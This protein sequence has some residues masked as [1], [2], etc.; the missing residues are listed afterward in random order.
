LLHELAQKHARDRRGVAARRRR[1]RVAR[2]GFDRRASARAGRPPSVID[3]PGADGLG[4]PPGDIV[5]CASEAEA[6]EA[7]CRAVAGGRAQMLMKGLV[8]TSAFLKGVL[9]KDWG[10]RRR[11]LLSHVAV[12]EFHGPDRLVLVTDVA[13]NIAPDVAGKSADHR[14]RGGTGDKLAS[15]GPASPHW[16]RLR[17]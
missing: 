10:L 17:P 9:N 1:A 3:S 6:I 13:M 2:P 4:R 12:F 5:E 14:Q 16:L 11:P 8:S 7:A 15:S